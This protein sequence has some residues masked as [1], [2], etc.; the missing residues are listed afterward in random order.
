MGC[1]KSV[2]FLTLGVIFKMKTTPLKPLCH[3]GF[4]ALGV[5]FPFFFTIKCEKKYRYIKRVENAKIFDIL[6][7]GV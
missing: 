1:E 6:T 4:R 2:I 7:L 3:K 5:V